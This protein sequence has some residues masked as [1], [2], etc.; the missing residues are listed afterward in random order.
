MTMQGDL[1]TEPGPTKYLLDSIIDLDAEYA[2]GDL[3]ETDYQE[4]RASYVKRAAMEL[5]GEEAAVSPVAGKRSSRRFAKIAASVVAVLAL[6]G[7]LGMFVARSAGQRLPTESITG[8][9]N[10]SSANKL[11]DAQSLEA[12]GQYVEALDTY[13][14]VLTTD[15]T[16][17]QALTYQAWL[18]ID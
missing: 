15:P 1:T 9:V 4:L 18:L 17:S 5:N 13:K 7:G 2:A 6:A 10:R 11:A 8:S 3:D 16:N 14:D 12:N